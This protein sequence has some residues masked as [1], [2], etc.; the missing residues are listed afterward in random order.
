[1]CFLILGE[2]STLVWL[3]ALF[4]LRLGQS[5]LCKILLQQSLDE[6]VTQLRPVL[7]WLL[8][9]LS[10]GQEAPEIVECTLLPL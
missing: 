8:Y 3:R 4:T 10:L 7:Y 9:T 5:L 2:N 1:M 6:E